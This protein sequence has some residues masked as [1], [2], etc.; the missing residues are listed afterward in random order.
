[1]TRTIRKGLTETFL[2]RSRPSP[3][4]PR[5]LQSRW[6][7]APLSALI[8]TAYVMIVILWT[9]IM[10]FF[11]MATFRSDRDRYRI[12]RLLRGSAVLAVR[13][14]PY[15]DFRVIDSVHPDPR[16]PYLFVSNH[17]S[18]ADAFLI[19]MLP[20]EMKWLSKR[21]I[22]RIPLLGWQ[23]RLAGDIA[24]ER[25]DKESARQAIEQM[26][27]R[28]ERKLSVIVFPEGT[29]SA[30]GSLGRFR[31][32]SFRLAI[33]QGVDIVPLAVAGTETALPKHSIIFRRTR[34]TVT[35]LPP[36][37][38]AGLTPGD[39][40]RLAETVRQKI[41]EELRLERANFSPAPA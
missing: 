31:E 37:S 34:A 15:W 11:R 35:V 26:R 24:L 5:V 20:W 36:V 6:L 4:I 10:A 16:R 27:K 40:G 38:T 1:M 13:I 30:D 9:P 28:L 39:A 14:N 23:M 25:A 33:E 2:R 3:R 18:F 8:W 32:G 19:S 41:A 7:A 12:G 21:S 22:M 17:C 29:R